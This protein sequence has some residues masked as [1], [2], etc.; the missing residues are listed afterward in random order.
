[1]ETGHSSALIAKHAG[2]DARIH[3]E[4]TRPAPDETLLARLKK[5]KLRIKEALSDD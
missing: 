3:A 1:M 5:Q 2:L 4:R